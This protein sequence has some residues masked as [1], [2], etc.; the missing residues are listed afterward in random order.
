ML[1][2]Y[3]KLSFSFSLFLSLSKIKI[4]YYL[5]KNMFRYIH[6][7]LNTYQNVVIFHFVHSFILHKVYYIMLYIFKTIVDKYYTVVQTIFY[8]NCKT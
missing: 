2:K 4:H 6:N 3:L 1:N 8:E 5:R 7:H